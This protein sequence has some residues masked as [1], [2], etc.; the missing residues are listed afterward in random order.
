MKPKSISIYI[1]AHTVVL[2]IVLDGPDLFF[3][4]NVVLGLCYAEFGAR[5]PK[6]GSAYI[7]SYVTIGELCAFVIGWN[8]LLEYIMGAAAVSKAWSDFFNSLCDDCVRDFFLKYIGSLKL[9]WMADYPDFLAFTFI[10][11]LTVVVI[12]GAAES[13]ALNWVFTILNLSVILFAT[14]AGLVFAEPKNWDNFSPFGFHGI[15]SGAA[16]CFF[17]FVGFDVIATLGEETK[18]PRKAIPRATIAALCKYLMYLCVNNDKN[19][20]KHA[21]L[22]KLV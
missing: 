9:H 15:M 16:T 5:V 7:Y 19:K 20:T 10:I 6:A 4:S 17:A 14:I 8:M 18:N 3:H 13:S 1:L 11:I 12:C 2:N 21:K 22:L